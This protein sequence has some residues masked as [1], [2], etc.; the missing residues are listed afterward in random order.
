MISDIAI[1]VENL[2]KQYRI[3]STQPG[4]RTLREFATDSLSNP[5]RRLRSLFHR[6]SANGGGLL[7]EDGHYVWALKDISFEIRR[8]EVIGVIGR[9]G[10][11]KSTLLKILSRITK[12]TEGRAWIN[13]RVGSLL[14]VGTGFHPELTGRENVFL[15]GAILGMR[16]A[17]LERQ[18][19]DIV[20]FSGVQRFIDTPVK[21]YSSGMQVRLGFAVAAHLEPDILLVDEVLAVGDAAFQRKCLGRMRDV[22]SK[23]RTVLF[24]SHNLNSIRRLC[25]KTLLLESGRLVEADETVRVIARY[26]SSLREVAKPSEWIDL[27]NVDRVGTGEAYFQAVWFSSD[28]KT[29]RLLPFSNGP[30]EFRLGIQSDASRSVSSVAVN[31]SDQFGTKLVNADTISLGEAVH[32][33]KGHNVV[34]LRISKLHLNPGTY[35]LGLWLA[36][37]GGNIF[38]HVDSA[39]SIDV[40]DLDSEGFG[41]RAPD[42]GAVTCHFEVLDST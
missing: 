18:F 10:A 13:G 26:L 39:I 23:G 34:R 8:G 30:L 2:S 27:S 7:E 9:N 5:H 14:E 11:G 1:R 21:R 22:A 42:D 16:K 24:V 28:N 25:P 12:P 31:L 36:N 4:N 38:D 41:I 20:E 35:S 32:L 6:Q 40:V 29:S 17:E 19:D 3:G 33:E 15:S 37:P